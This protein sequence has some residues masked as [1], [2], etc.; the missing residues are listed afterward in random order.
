MVVES[1]AIALALE[2]I[3][4]KVAARVLEE[5]L[6]RALAMLSPFFTGWMGAT[7]GL[8][9]RIVHRAPL[10]RSVAFALAFLLGYTLGKLAMV[11]AISL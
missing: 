1:T 10:S 4:S 6:L 3:R 2:E 9:A 5:P 11:A 7:A 8:G